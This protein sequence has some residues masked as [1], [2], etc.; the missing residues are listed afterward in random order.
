MNEQTLI[1]GAGHAAGQLVASLRQKGYEGRIVLLGDEPYLPY[2]RPPLSKKFLAGELPAERLFVKPAAFYDDQDIDVRLNT[3]VASIDREAKTVTTDSGES[4]PYTSL[5]IAT[6]ARVNRL[7]CPGAELNG[8]HYLRNIEDVDAIREDCKDGARV[9][10]VG[11]G[12][13][14]LEV[15]AVL[16]EMG[17]DVVVLETADRVMSRVVSPPVS[18][19]FESVHRARGVDLKLSTGLQSFDGDQR[20][21]A[22]VTTDG[23]RIEGDVAIVGIGIRPNTELA[24]AAG[25]DV[26]NGIVVDAHCRTT[27][28]DI[29]AIGDCTRHPSAVYERS[30]RL[31]SVQNALEQA[32]TAAANIAGGDAE[33]N[34]V[35]WFWSDQYHLKLQIAGLSEGFDD[36]VLRGDP[37]DEHFSCAYLR[38]GRLIAIDSINAPKDFMLS[39]ALIKDAC[40]IDPERLA[41]TSLTM[42]DMRQD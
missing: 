38:D 19:F 9:V 2:Q 42:R 18:A 10:I 28:A 5:A 39:K 31:E 4:I 12:Y 14:G 29:Y 26:D 24:E 35:P 23:D 6:G 16:R 1:I 33:Y 37:A 3:R 41:D 11:A 17:S 30:L 34:E 25:L 36:Y 40:R 13:I 22:A 15:A 27:D 7:S 32:K 8:I 20:F 21:E